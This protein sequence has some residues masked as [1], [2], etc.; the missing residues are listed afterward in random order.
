MCPASSGWPITVGTW[1]VDGDLYF[2]SGQ[3][4]EVGCRFYGEYPSYVFRRID[5]T[6]EQ[7][8]ILIPGNHCERD[9]VLS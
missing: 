3:C 9:G 2:S 6:Y 7:P 8:V 5:S 4:G 1:R